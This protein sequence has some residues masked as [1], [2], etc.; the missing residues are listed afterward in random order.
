M[1][2]TQVHDRVWRDLGYAVR[3]TTSP[4]ADG[5]QYAVSFE[6]YEVNGYECDGTR[7][8]YY[9]DAEAEGYEYGPPV[10]TRK[11]ATR[12]G[13]ETKDMGEAEVFLRAMVKWDGCAELMPGD[14]HVCGKAEAAGIGAMLARLYDLAAELMPE[15]KGELA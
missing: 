5:W 4:N 11:D 8:S 3:A 10:F 14:W 2:L 7:E 1:S 9:A 6:V 12:S 13:D 15:H